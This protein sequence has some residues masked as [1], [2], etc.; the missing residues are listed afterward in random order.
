MNATRFSLTIVSIA[1]V[2]LVSL[3]LPL[4]VS[5]ATDGTTKMGCSGTFATGETGTCSL[6]FESSDSVYWDAK[7][8][9]ARMTS[10]LGVGWKVEGLI[11]DGVGD[12]YFTWSC[13]VDA[14]AFSPTGQGG[15][16][17]SSCRTS[18]FLR[19]HGNSP[20]HPGTHTVTVTATADFCSEGD[21]GL[22]PYKATVNVRPGA[23][24]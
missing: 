16:V 11:T 5:A 21:L 2:T 15:L 18:E 20:P 7:S 6:T 1:T 24:E 17:I 8:A 23:L 13:E 9:Y 19:P 12:P 10:V 3:G 4:G 14:S 22:C